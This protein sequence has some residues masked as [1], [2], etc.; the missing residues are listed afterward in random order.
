MLRYFV[1]H[2]NRLL[3]RGALLNAVWPGIHVTE[4][5]FK[6]VVQQLRRALKENP[7]APYSGAAVLQAWKFITGQG[8][9][10]YRRT[11]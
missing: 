8:K 6:I 9:G 5:Q 1:T 11:R 3:T 2:P 4:S 10:G 7:R